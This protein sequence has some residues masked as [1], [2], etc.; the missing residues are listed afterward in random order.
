MTEDEK[1]QKWVQMW[2][3]AASNLNAVKRQELQQEDYY[4]KHRELLNSMLQ[5]AFEQREI[6]YTSGLV[7]QQKWFRKIYE[8]T[9]SGEK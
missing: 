2:K 4:L 7:E 3:T 1:I 5:Y 6:R 9:L 8:Q